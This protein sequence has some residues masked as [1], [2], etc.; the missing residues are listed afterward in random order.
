[1]ITLIRV[2][3]TVVIFI[4]DPHGRYTPTVLTAELV[5]GAGLDWTVEFIFTAQ[6]TVGCTVTTFGRRYTP[7]DRRRQ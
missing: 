7:A 1:M 6:L 3:L 2:V 4:T 5:R